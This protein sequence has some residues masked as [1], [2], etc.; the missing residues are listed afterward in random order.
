MKQLLTVK[1]EDLLEL[2]AVAGP[3]EA[4]VLA[5]I[6]DAGADATR[7]CCT[8]PSP[9]TRP[10]GPPASPPSC[11][12]DRR[13]LPRRRECRAPR[14]RLQA[15]PAPAALAALAPGRTLPA[16][17]TGQPAP[18]AVLFADQALFDLLT[19]VWR[20]GAGLVDD[21]PAVLR[22]LAR[23][24]TRPA[25]PL[26]AP[27][28]CLDTAVPRPS[29]TARSMSRAPA[30]DT[31]W[32]GSGGARAG[33]LLGYAAA[34]ARG[35]VLPEAV[36]AL[37]AGAL[38]LHRPADEFTAAHFELYVLTSAGRR[39]AAPAPYDPL[40][41]TALGPGRLLDAVRGRLPGADRAP[42]PGPADRYR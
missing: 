12:G 35:G 39:L 1:E 4:A 16:P 41:L 6:E 11:G 32:L 8:A 33:C 17:A 20:T 7:S 28:P 19:L 38:A 9:P 42:R 37:V 30:G 18:S 14:R 40:L 29:S 26:L 2:A 13:V 27:P 25:A 15:G 10:P 22:R 31:A 23:S 21:L 3:L 34:Q 5:A 24:L 36:L